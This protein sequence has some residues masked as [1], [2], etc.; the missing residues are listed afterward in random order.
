MSKFWGATICSI[1]ERLFDHFKM[2]FSL[3]ECLGLG[4]VF[5]DL[6]MLWSKQFKNNI[7]FSNST[8]IVKREILAWI[9]P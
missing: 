5:Y 3:S 2:V 6:I 8:V 9:R 1:N 4:V 7:I